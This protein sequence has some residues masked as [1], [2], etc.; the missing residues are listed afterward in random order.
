MSIKANIDFR[1]AINGLELLGKVRHQLARSMAVA[2]GKV[3]RDEAKSR[4]PVG[5]DSKNPGT[6]RDAIYLAYRDGESTEAVE[7]YSVSWNAKKA[8]HGHL[9]EFGH[10][11]THAR[12]KGKD[13]EWYTGAPLA[14]P[15]WVPAY[16]F[17]RPALDAAL[18]RAKAAMLERGR[19]RLPEL[20]AGQG[21]GDEL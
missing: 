9:V 13:G 16:P 12:Y 18:P 7:V 1:D 3:L 10:W 20:L 15:K 17:L 6:L 8:P 19:E 14:A 2:G 5:E 21:G 11:Q 4:A